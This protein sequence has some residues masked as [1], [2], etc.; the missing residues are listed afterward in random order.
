MGFSNEGEKAKKSG[1]RPTVGSDGD[2]FHH[3]AQAISTAITI[4][5][6]LVPCF[7]LVFVVFFLNFGK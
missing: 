3:K 6:L 2:Q 4:L 5:L 7:R 1:G